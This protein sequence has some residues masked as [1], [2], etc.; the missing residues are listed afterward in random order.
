MRL[1]QFV[2]LGIGGV[3]N[4]LVE[5]SDVPVVKGLK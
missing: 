3:A 4:P 1:G 2:S 5:A